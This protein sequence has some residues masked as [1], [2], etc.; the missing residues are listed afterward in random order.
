MKAAEQLR[1]CGQSIWL[2]FINQDLIRSGELKQMAEHGDLTGVISNPT[3]FEKAIDGDRSNPRLTRY[4]LYERL[5]IED[6]R[7]TADI[8]GGVYDHTHSP[9]QTFLETPNQLHEV[10][11]N[12]STTK[13]ARLLAVTLS[14]KGK[15]LTTPA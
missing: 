7:M 5:S 6:V 4:Q 8:L 9:G 15:Q 13:P 3:I 1:Q 10:S 2:D 12:A 14:G 11:R